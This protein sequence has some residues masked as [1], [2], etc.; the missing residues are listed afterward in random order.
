VAGEQGDEMSYLERAAIVLMHLAIWL[1]GASILLEPV[2]NAGACVVTSGLFLL[3]GVSIL[4]L[5]SK[6]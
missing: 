5:E 1:L 4:A 2:E 3:L 6:P